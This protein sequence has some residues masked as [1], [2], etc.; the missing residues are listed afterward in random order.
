MKQP[1]TFS[2]LINDARVA[3]FSDERYDGLTS[4]GLWLYL[5]PGWVYDGFMNTVH[6]YTVADCCR[7]MKCV[8]YQPETYYDVVCTPHEPRYLL[9][10]G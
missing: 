7:A 4:D 1:R 10:A 9:P 6:E 5:M 3:H 2:G 8:R